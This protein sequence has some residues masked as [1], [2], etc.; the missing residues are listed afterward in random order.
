MI[1]LPNGRI[2]R[3][4]IPAI[5]AAAIA[6]LTASAAETS[7]P[8]AKATESWDDGHAIRSPGSV[9][10]K[11]L[12]QGLGELNGAAGEGDTFGTALSGPTSGVLW[13]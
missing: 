3:R 7:P 2:R 12:V 11:G 1:S 13:D 9:F 6:V 8:P 4:A 5:M 10:D